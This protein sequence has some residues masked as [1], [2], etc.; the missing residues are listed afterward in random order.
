M[1]TKYKGGV[2]FF[3]KHKW[4]GVGTLVAACGLLVY[5]MA[6]AKTSLVPNEDTGSLFISVD[7]APGTTLAET[8]DI[9]TEMQNSIK[10]IEEGACVPTRTRAILRSLR[11][12][13]PIR[14]ISR[15]RRSSSSHLL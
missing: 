4:V 9:L 5:F 11:R 10:D 6:T 15:T 14:P 1:I 2:K 13:T 8:N 12:Y 7:A 3:I